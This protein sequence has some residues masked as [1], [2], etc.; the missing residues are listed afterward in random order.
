MS[1]AA[2]LGGVAAAALLAGCGA[3]GPVQVPAAD[4][5]TLGL[6]AA[7][8]FEAAVAAPVSAPAPTPEDLRWW[9]RFDDP[10]LAEWVERALA[11]A[12]SLARAGEQ[13]QQAQA[14]L[15]AARAQ[16][17]P[18]LGAGLRA[19]ARLRRDPGE[20]LFAPQAALSLDFDTNLWGGLAQA[21]RSA[22]AGVLR[23]RHLL[24]AARLAAAGLAARAYV[25]WRTAALDE[26]LLVDAQAL[27][28]EALRVVDVRVEAGLS[29][30]LDRQRAR[31][32]LAA[33]QA[34]LAAAG[35]RRR[36][37]ATALQ[38]LAGQRPQPL[39][40]PSGG[41]DAGAGAAPPAPPAPPALSGV[42]PTV[43][44]LD[45]LRLRPDLLAAEQALVAA[46]AEVGVAD[47]ALRPQLRLPGALVFATA[48]GGAAIEL[49][50]ATLAAL[51]ELNLADG[52]ARDAAAD[53]ARSRLREVQAVYRETLLQA[54]RQVQDAIGASQGAAERSAARERAAAAGAA[55]VEQAQVLYRAGLSGFLDLADAQRSA[56]DNRRDALQARADAAVAAV[57]TFEALGLVDPAPEA[58]PAQAALSPAE[59]ASARR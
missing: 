34:T 19:E 12:P 57:A 46:A 27:Q 39:A 43:R 38:V 54:L 5:P 25:E 11:Q 17:R 40:G 59:T 22:A 26:A 9:R 49:V 42:A 48:G 15:V 47:A 1:G 4:A 41:A 7:D 28:R 20:R 33:V 51:L 8:R 21:E 58:A 36:R 35:E 24:Q 50:G 10:A 37:A 56:L 14:Q 53:A 6:T 3:F 29:P 23:Q 30:L 32:E 55:A 52:G 44:P 31:A 2:R 18:A 16:R 13:L 45:L